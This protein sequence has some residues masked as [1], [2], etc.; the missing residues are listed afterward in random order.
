M[1]NSSINP[2]GNNLV[3]NLNFTFLP[4]FA[5]VKSNEGYVQNIAGQNS[6]LQTLG[7]WT[8]T[9]GTPI[10]TATSVTP[11]SG[12]G[13]GP[14]VFTYT[15]SDS[16]G[17]ANISYGYSMLSSS[18]GIANSCLVLFIRS[19]DSFYLLNDSGSQFLGPITGG[20]NTTLSNSQCILN[21]AGSGISGTGNNL[22][23]KAQLSFH[24][25]FA[26]LK[27]NYAYVVNS[28]GQASPLQNLGTWN[29]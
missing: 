6:G 3:E 20:S 5:G 15:Y 29:P 8:V 23:V 28:S 2:S 16:S 1:R 4:A 11:N 17:Y 25:A 13:L 12:A 18:G 9:G 21:A 14:Q 19:S 7:S 26:G 27:T 22:S 24:A 10:L